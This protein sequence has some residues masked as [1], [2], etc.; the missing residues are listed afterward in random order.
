MVHPSTTRTPVQ[1][2]TL[3]NAITVSAVDCQLMPNQQPTSL[4]LTKSADYYE[5]RCVKYPHR[6]CF[7][8]YAEFIHAL[9][10]EADAEV[11]AFVPQPYCLR[12]G[13]KL[14]TPDVYIVR[15]GR[16]T[17]RELK[18]AGRSLS[19]GWVEALEAFFDHQGMHFEMVS[20]ETVLEH[21]SLALHWLPIVQILA[22]ARLDGVDTNLEENQLL[23][24]LLQSRSLAVGELL[25]D[26]ARDDRYR[27]E[28]ALLRLL[29][30]HRI[31]ADLSEAPWDY[32]T[33]V[34]L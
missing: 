22:E 6:A 4:R 5:Q 10:L 29:H 20:N 7:H 8:S 1:S 27:Q 28:L 30:Q 9:L 2:V 32:D 19:D 3:D 15:Q 18:P 26:G 21:E 11:I 31:G 33:V 17:I 23:N 16:P 34:W 13:R 25:T 14:Y 12:I 24:Q